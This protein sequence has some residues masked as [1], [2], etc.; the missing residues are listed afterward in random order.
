MRAGKGG[1][2]AYLVRMASRV[3][4]RSRQ[5]RTC[6]RWPRS[7]ASEFERRKFSDQ[8]LH[9]SD[10]QSR[11][12]GRLIRP[13]TACEAGLFEHARGPREALYP[14]RTAARQGGSRSTKRLATNGSIA[15][16]QALKKAH[17]G[18]ACLDSQSCGQCIV[19]YTGL[20]CPMNCPKK[21]RNGPC[22]GVRPDGRCEV[23][24]ETGT[25]SGCRPGKATRT[26]ACQT[27][28]PI[29]VGSA[30]RSTTA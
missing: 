11:V 13:C 21:M 18:P 9:E 16:L 27:D 10:S 8:R 1:S 28:Y 19:G 25:A 2:D 7:A 29:Q 20:S 6:A 24:P 22:G 17:Q 3:N 26:A 15:H 12:G 30:T 14:L 23:E 4:P 5:Q